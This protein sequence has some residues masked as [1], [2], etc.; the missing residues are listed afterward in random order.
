MIHLL[1]KLF[2]AFLLPP[3]LFVT[4]ALAGAL[5]FRRARY[6]LLGIALALYAL[7]I[8]PV[9]DSLLGPLENPYRQTGLPE[10]ADVVVSLGGGNIR[11]NPIPLTDEALKR[12]LF[13]L[14]IAKQL[15]IPLI[16]SGTGD[17]GYDEFQG[18]VDSLRALSPLLCDDIEVARRYRRTYVVIPETRSGDTYENARFSMAL[19]DKKEPTVIVVT[20]AYHMRRAL[21][22][23]RLAGVEHPY[24]AAVN[25]YIAPGRRYDWRS[26]VPSIWAFL[27]SYRALHEYAG[28]V[29]VWMREIRS[30]D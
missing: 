7:S 17:E 20:S 16:V 2:T 12:H 9:A 13:G 28:L 14:S 23:F 1:S 15:D 8:E 30:G 10:R 18:L 26:F 19:V 27:N 29:K 3:G 6:Y 25:F 5:L 4:L 21:R 24:P 22:L 11:G